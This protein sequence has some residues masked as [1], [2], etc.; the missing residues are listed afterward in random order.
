MT[1]DLLAFPRGFRWG[2][3]TAAHQNEGNN[4]DNNW[5][6]WEQTPGRI[7]QGY[8]CGDSTNWWDL[9][10]AARDFDR[11]AD[12]GLNAMR[13]S[14]EWSRIEPEPGS[15][16]REALGHYCEMVGLLQERG[17]EPMVTLHHFTDP[18][19]L[20][21][22]G[23]WENPLV[24]DY[25]ARFTERVVDA[26]G[27]Q[28]NLWCTINEPIVYAFMGFKDGRFPPGGES[29]P[30]AVKVLRNMLLAH[31]RSYRTIH[32]LQNET[33]VGLAHHL[34]YF[35]PA[36]PL[37]RLDR[38]AVQFIDQMAN[39]ST[40][41]AVTSGRLTFPLGVGQTVGELIDSSDY[42]G[43]NYYSTAHMAFDRSQAGMLFARQHLVPSLDPCESTSH[44]EPFCE[45]NPEG[46]YLA[47]RQC[48]AYGKPI[49]IT[50]N[51]LP[52]RDDDQ[53]PFLLASYL[54]EVWR[55][56]RDGMD[57]RGYYHWTLVDNFEWAEGWN[58][59]FGLFELD[60][61]TGERTQRASAAVYARIA[62]ANGVPRSVVARFAPGTV[63]KYFG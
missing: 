21:R 49:Y 6:L 60:P 14:V 24:A 41:E 32:R 42:I 20:G 4:C 34:R 3:A 15:F 1:K 46:I 63:G 25:F 38:L 51:G 19:W 31:A 26:L 55:A 61:D 57:V 8:V 37:S 18:L 29:L 7:H 33:M 12:L 17:M 58:L 54:P 5:A 10:V 43:L 36:N 45:L 22:E 48:T 56:I 28:V 9:N 53:R 39:R 23:G 47:L 44:G 50:E 30:R 13:I 35:L 59:R 52:D 11:A 62:Q 27:G 2:V 40:L 16:N